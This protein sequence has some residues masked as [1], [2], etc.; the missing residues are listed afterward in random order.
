[1]RHQV[2]EWEYKTITFET[3][4]GALDTRDFTDKLNVYGEQKWEAVSCF[5]T[6]SGKGATRIIFVLL[7]RKI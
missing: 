7:K 2:D 3:P 6:N 4:A 5:G 1:M